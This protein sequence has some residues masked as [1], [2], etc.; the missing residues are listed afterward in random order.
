MNRKPVWGIL[1]AFTI[2]ALVAHAQSAQLDAQTARPAATNKSVHYDRMPLG[3]EPNQGQTS[4]QV[5]WLARGP[6]YTLFLS[7]HDAVLQLNHI[8]PGSRLGQVPEVSSTAVWMKL[9]GANTAAAAQAQEPESG[10]VNYFT[11]NDPAKWQRNIGLYGRILLEKV[12]PGIDL[13][14]YGHQGRLEYDF[15]VA[16]G[17]DPSAIRIAFSGSQ[18]RL[19]GNGDL[20]LPIKDT[21]MRFAKPV[22][23]QVVDGERRRVEG[24]FQ[25]AKNGDLSFRLGPYDHTQELV[26]DPTLVYTGTF[27]TASE[28]DV[29]SGMAVDAQGELII[30]GTTYDLNFPATSGAD[31]TS[32]GPVSSTDTQNGVFRC[33]TGDQPGA[34]SSAYVAKLSA[35]GTS[36][37]YATYLHGVTGWETG[38]AV[39]ADASGNAVVVGQTSSSDFPLVKAPAIPQMSLCQPE[40]SN[41]GSG[42]AVQSC[43]GYYNGGG[44]EWTIRGPSGFIS[45]LSADGSSLLYSAFIG[46]SGAT[47]PQALALD[48]SGKMYLLNELNTADP[49]PNP[50]SGSEVFYPTNSG[51]QTA[52]VG[53]IGTALTVL[54][55]DGQTILYSTIWGGT[56]PIASG[57][58]SCLNG[59]VP[60]ALAVGQNG[61][62]FIAGETRVPTLPVTAGTVQTTCLVETATQCYDNVGY[63]AAFDISKTGANSLAWATYISGPDNPNTA[64][65][66]QLNAIAADS[67]NNVYLTGY[68][69]DALF[70]ITKDAYAA[71][72]PLDSRSG[73]NFCDNDIFVSKLNATGTAYDWSTFLTTTQGAASNGDSKGIALDAKGD[74]Y[75]YGDSGTLNIPA[76]NPLSQYPNDWY[77]PYPFLSVLAST[78][79]SL[80]FSSQIAPNNYVSA[81]ENGMAL[82]AKDNIYLVGNTQGGQ[83]YSVGNTT[84]TSW[85]TTKG[86][87]STPQSG[88]GPIPFF[89][90]IAALLDPTTTTLSASP[91]TTAVG[92]KVTFTAT[93]TSSVQSSP[94][95]SGTVTLTNTAVKPN[96]TIGTIDLEAGT[97]TFDT[98]SL[99][100]GTYTVVGTY[101]ADS[102]Y[103]ASAS[104]PVTVTINTGVKA[105]VTLSVPA[106]AGAGS[107]VTMTAM[108]SGS[109]GT[110]TGTVSFYDGTTELGTGAL[111]SGMATYKTSSLA[112]GAHTITAQYSGDSNFGAAVSAAQ[113]V[114]ITAASPDFSIAAS[115]TSATIAGGGTTTTTVTV[116]PANGF[117][118]PTALSCSGLPANATCSFSPASVTPG[119]NPATSTLTITT[120][121]SPTASAALTTGGG[122]LTRFGA[123]GSGGALLAFLF[124]PGMGRR[125]QRQL[126]LRMLA[127]AAIC[128][129]GAQGLTGCGGSQ[130]NS[131]PGSV[132]P[133]GSSTIT[134]TGTAGSTTHATTFSLTVS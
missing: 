132:T 125:R 34:M 32:C 75:V 102:V 69:T 59:T 81:M 98:S 35:D 128:L 53:D 27:A 10:K 21:E 93:V 11:G 66:T 51:F 58:G 119:A 54:S 116:T 89:A 78:G 106:S 114:T 18:P 105:T 24:D 96:V 40:L 120:N 74:V 2:V 38:A 70:P 104:S 123:V 22:A 17:A 43:N 7:G 111:S 50:G 42:P 29:P 103:D 110:P 48:A 64:V 124:W 56:K 23:Y 28:S 126:W 84:L 52:G 19:A 57:C 36:L 86:T 5:Q 31:Q 95:P 8:A 134:I 72:C 47:Y 112:V 85:P 65:S 92:Q 44:T 33:A 60:S 101:S 127:F 16:P 131:G 94:D 25:M 109:S 80:R 73:A 129:L 99:A 113:T 82:D 83:T 67:E 37:I 61:M 49:N 12:Y 3:F 15:I 115:P 30:T 76:V 77:Q 108:V 91:S 39:Q 6:E 41:N 97:G 87:Y 100:A 45:K 13:A 14:Y 20:L 62:V 90:K 107:S 68:T 121:V 133:T 88:T 9:P 46:Y 118:V 79:S 26:I 130:R 1:L 71:T 4:S 55:A 122:I 117:N 63:V